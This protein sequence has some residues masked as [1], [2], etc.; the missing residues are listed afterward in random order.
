M[1]GENIDNQKIENLFLDTK[2]NQRSRTES[3]KLYL[4]KI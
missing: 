3:E 2:L 1:K 4:V